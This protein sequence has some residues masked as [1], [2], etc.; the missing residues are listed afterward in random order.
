MCTVEKDRVASCQIAY[1][2]IG[3]NNYLE[4]I[5]QVLDLIQSYS[6]EYEIGTFS[7]TVRGARRVI[8]QLIQDIYDRM[9]KQN[10]RFTIHIL[11]SNTC[12][13]E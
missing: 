2:P 5:Q 9:D 8:F 3:T 11:L 6:V 12:G 7:T 10:N 1:F 13:C 4:E